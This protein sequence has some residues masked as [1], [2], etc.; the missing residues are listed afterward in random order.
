M[1]KS[2]ILRYMGANAS[3]DA[4][5]RWIDRAEREVR[6][7]A[8]PR[9]VTRRCA[10]RVGLRTVVFE[11]HPIESASLAAH[12]RGCDEAF[13][14]AVTLGPGVDLLLRRYSVT[15][16]PYVPVLQAAAAA[17]VEEY[18][19]QVGAVELEP[20]AARHGL[21]QRPRY[22]PGYGDFALENQRFFFDALG[23]SKRIGV[24]L[25][26]GCMM[27]PSKSVTAVVG[28]SSDP[29]LCHVGKCMVCDMKNCPFRKEEG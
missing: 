12:L 29:S 4:L 19:D 16:M 1:N 7:A 2:E 8:V 11:G 18:A 10:I 15:E 14:L 23:I 28:L 5:D 3:T 27:I 20:Y 24:S 26:E 6:A 21:Y 9:S 13:L 17:C 22:S 25:T